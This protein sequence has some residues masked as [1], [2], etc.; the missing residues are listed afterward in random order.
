MAAGCIE[1]GILVGTDSFAPE[2]FSIL[3]RLTE[4]QPEAV[5]A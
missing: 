5:T 3:C 1:I 2:I 4:I